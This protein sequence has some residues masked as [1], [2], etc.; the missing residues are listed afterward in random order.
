[1][2]AAS[3]LVSAGALPEP[4][5]G[6]APELD[7]PPEEDLPLLRSTT[8]PEPE[9]GATELLLELAALGWLDGGWLPEL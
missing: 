9:L 8:L 3:S 5:L 6:L 4:E 7:L 1:M 2:G